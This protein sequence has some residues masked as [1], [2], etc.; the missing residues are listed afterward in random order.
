[1]DDL[2]TTPAR[3]ALPLEAT[4]I[5]QLLIEYLSECVDLASATIISDRAAQVPVTNVR[6]LHRDLPLAEKGLGRTVHAIVE[7]D[8][9]YASFIVSELPFRGES[10]G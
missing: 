2:R 7:V 8:K 3:E 1:M 5:H 10:S 6:K 9:R 4:L